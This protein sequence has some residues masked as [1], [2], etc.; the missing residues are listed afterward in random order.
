[1]APT[2]LNYRTQTSPSTAA[3]ITDA[4]ADLASGGSHETVAARLLTDGAKGGRTGGTNPVA[5]WLGRQ[6]PGSGLWGLY[7][8]WID[9]HVMWRG[10]ILDVPDAVFAFLVLFYAGRY[11]QLSTEYDWAAPTQATSKRV[12]S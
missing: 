9:E 5:V 3:Q 12:A 7:G 8:A 10:Q 11:P 1:M 2:T 4:L 6:V